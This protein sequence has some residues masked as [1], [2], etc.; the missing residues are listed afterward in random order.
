MSWG[1][2]GEGTAGRE[3]STSTGLEGLQ[4]REDNGGPYSL[5]GRRHPSSE[6]VC[7]E[8]GVGNGGSG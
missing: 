4:N 5:V 2:L 6:S 8:V 1:V 3:M 7:L